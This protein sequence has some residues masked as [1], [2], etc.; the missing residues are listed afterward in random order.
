MHLWSLGVSLWYSRLELSKLIVIGLISRTRSCPNHLTWRTFRRTLR[1]LEI[2]PLLVDPRAPLT[3]WRSHCTPAYGSRVGIS[4]LA[5]QISSS[6]SPGLE[7]PFHSPHPRRAPRRKRSLRVPTASPSS[8]ALPAPRRPT[9]MPL[10]YGRGQ[11][12][13]PVLC[14]APSSMWSSTILLS[15]SSVFGIIGLAL[16]L[17]AALTDNW[18]E[19]Q[20]SRTSFAALHF[21]LLRSSICVP[22][23]CASRAY[24][25]PLRLRFSQ[26]LMLTV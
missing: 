18:T 24:R 25:S 22:F 14:A 5:A 12:A 8:V 4:S 10:P 11:S 20:V 13:R 19:Y 26:Y 21:R 2:R 3:T 17:T 9:A 16:V 23:P 6:R 7:L 1:V 15:L